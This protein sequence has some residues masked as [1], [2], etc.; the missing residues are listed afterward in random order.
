VI[1]N[2]SFYGIALD[3]VNDIAIPLNAANGVLNLY[4]TWYFYRWNNNNN[5]NP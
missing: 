3:A 2:K 5:N 4:N 1:V